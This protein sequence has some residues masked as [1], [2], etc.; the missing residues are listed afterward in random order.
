[1]RQIIV[2]KYISG[3]CRDYP[4]YLLIFGTKHTISESNK[5]NW[6]FSVTWD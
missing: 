6:T 3:N 4:P 2:K 1:M 5:D